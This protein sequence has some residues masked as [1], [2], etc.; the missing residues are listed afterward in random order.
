MR[1]KERLGRLGGWVGSA[2]PGDLFEAAVEVDAAEEE[3]DEEG[4][5]EDGEEGIGEAG[6]GAGDAGVE[7]EGG[8]DPEDGDDF[9]GPHGGEGVEEGDDGEAEEEEE[10]E[11]APEGEG[12]GGWEEEGEVFAPAFDEGWGVAIHAGGEHLR[13]VA[14]AEGAGGALE[15]AGEGY[16]FEDF[17]AD[18]AVASDGGVGFGVDEEELAVG[19]GEAVGAVGDEGGGVDAG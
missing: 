19:G 9:A 13:G 3:V 8:A 17:R 2:F 18:G 11:D 5:A 6:V 1:A 15:V 4:D 16:V 12:D 10:I 7:A 14:E